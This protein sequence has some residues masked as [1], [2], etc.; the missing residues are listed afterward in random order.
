MDIVYKI[1]Q[2]LTAIILVIYFYFTNYWFYRMIPIVF[3]FN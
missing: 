1:L 3:G 2:I